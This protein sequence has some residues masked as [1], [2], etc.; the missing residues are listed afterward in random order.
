M[1]AGCSDPPGRGVRS[2]LRADT[3]CLHHPAPGLELLTPAGVVGSHISIVRRPAG[4]GS[5]TVRGPFHV[6]Q[7][8]YG[9]G[10][11]VALSDAA[12]VSAGEGTS[13]EP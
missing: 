10:R 11:L 1:D 13:T 7:D 3:A 9:S 6:C 4:F 8:G 2:R 5:F 12:P